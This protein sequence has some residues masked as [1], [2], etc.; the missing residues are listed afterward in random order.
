[1]K[2]KQQPAD[3]HVEELT[4]VQPGA[5]GPYAFYRLDKEGW[6][7]PDAAAFI[8]RRWRL[9]PN[10]IACGGLKDRHAWTRQFITISDGPRRGLRQHGLVLDYLGQVPH[11]Y[12]STDLIGNRFRLS[13]RDLRPTSRPTYEI[14]LEEMRRDGVPNYFDD[15][16]FGSVGTDGQFIARELVHGRFE[17]ALRLALTGA[18]EHDRNAAKREKAVLKRLWGDWPACAAKLPHGHERNLIAYLTHHPHDFRGAMERLRPELHGLYLSAYQSHLWNRMLALWLT[19]NVPP[20]RLITVPLRLG[21][22]PMH[23]QLNEDQRRAL[24]ELRL[25][26][27]AARMSFV[28]DDPR[29]VLAREVLANEELTWEKLKVPGSRKLFFSRGDRSALLQPA[30]LAYAFQADEH[31]PGQLKC[32][33]SFDLPRGGYATMIVKRATSGSSLC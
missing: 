18:Y 7:T 21:P 4:S 5:H 33:L 32:V 26:L 19:R 11:A 8:R 14:A 20:E 29:F 27:P 16:R 25:P 3:F 17:E 2:V 15:Q 24:S 9:A 10:R 22:A 23:R 1:M 28:A 30:N 31:H 6:T 13:L 12:S